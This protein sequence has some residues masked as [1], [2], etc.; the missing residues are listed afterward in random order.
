MRLNSILL[1]EHQKQCLSHGNGLLI[2]KIEAI[3]IHK[4]LILGLC[5][6]ILKSEKISHIEG[7]F[8]EYCSYLMETCPEYVS[9]V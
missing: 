7:S 4:Y 2:R 3:P 1:D 6:V 9:H 8:K 5:S